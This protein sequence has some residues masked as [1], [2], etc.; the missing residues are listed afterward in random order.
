MQFLINPKTTV[1]FVEGQLR[2]EKIKNKKLFQTV[3]QSQY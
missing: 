2:N 1:S 3:N